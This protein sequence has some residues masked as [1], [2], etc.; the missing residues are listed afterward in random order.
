ML[1]QLIAIFH[2]HVTIVDKHFCIT[3]LI[4]TAQWIV[5][6]RASS[7]ACVFI[8]VGR[9]LL[10]CSRHICTIHSGASNYSNCSNKQK[11]QQNPNLHYNTTIDIVRGNNIDAFTLPITT[12]T[13]NI[14]IVCAFLSFG[15]QHRK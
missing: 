7:R 2:R 5:R 13:N 3:N 6:F 1:C 10:M 12:E 15:Q 4:N 9:M 8:I 11:N 14:F